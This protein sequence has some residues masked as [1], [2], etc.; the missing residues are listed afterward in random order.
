M[1]EAMSVL[2]GHNFQ[3][4]ARGSG[5]VVGQSPEPGRAVPSGELVRLTLEENK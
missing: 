5:I 4:E 3:L 2:S 1:G